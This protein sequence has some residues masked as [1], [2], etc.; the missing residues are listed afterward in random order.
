[1]WMK[2]LLKKKTP[3]FKPWYTGKSMAQLT[4]REKQMVW[5]IWQNVDFNLNMCFQVLQYAP[6]N[7]QIDIQ[8]FRSG[9]P[10]RDNN[11]WTIHLGIIY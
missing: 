2:E 10:V 6:G 11:K 7:L 8:E 3:R 9:D 1:M 4:S 5:Q